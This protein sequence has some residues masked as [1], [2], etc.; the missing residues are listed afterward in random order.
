MRAH[1]VLSVVGL[2]LLLAGCAP[3]A[4]PNPSGFASAPTATATA[5]SPSTT[6]TEPVSNDSSAAEQTDLTPEVLAT[7]CVEKTR[8]YFAADAQFFP[9]RVRVEARKVDPPW[10]VIVP[11]VTLGADA[12]AVC[13]IGG[14]AASP[15]FE[16]HAAQQPPTEQEIQDAIDGVQFYEGD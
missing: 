14:T 13:T 15:T 16:A 11:A 7:L 9:E 10:L 2:T 8:S 12:A 5:T 1:K 4:K 3:D 6:S